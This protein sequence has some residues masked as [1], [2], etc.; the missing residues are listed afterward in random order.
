MRRLGGSLSELVS[1]A[2]ARHL[3]V[4][5]AQVQRWSEASAY[6]WLCDALGDPATDVAA[7]V[8]LAAARGCGSAEPDA[9]ARFLAAEI[10][11][12]SLTAIALPE[13]PR[14]RP[15]LYRSEVPDL[16]LIHI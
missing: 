4:P 14:G 10:A 2:G 3:L 5:A 11:D 9:V 15:V 1:A 7:I 13:P 16:S 8:E 12:G 6:A